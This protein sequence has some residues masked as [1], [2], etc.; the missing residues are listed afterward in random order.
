[1]VYIDVELV[2]YSVIL[3]KS[4]IIRPILR[5]TP[6]FKRSFS[7]T[8]SSHTAAST[9]TDNELRNML[10]EGALAFVPQCGWSEDALALSV[11]QL[12]YLYNILFRIHKSNQ[13][14]Y[15]FM[16]IYDW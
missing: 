13:Y 16:C 9:S 6:G 5:S 7:R 2:T 8:F 10:L 15:V 4:I 14:Q 1:V 11:K 3:M 12:G